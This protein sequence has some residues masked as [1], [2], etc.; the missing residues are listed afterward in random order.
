MHISS[1]LSTPF[2]LPK[3]QK[4][5][6][7]SLLIC[8]LLIP[9][10]GCGKRRPPT[11]PVN[12]NKI[13]QTDFSVFQQGN[14]IGLVIPLKNNTQKYQKA[15][16]YRLAESG[17]AP[18]FLTEEEFASR[19]TLVGSISFSGAKNENEVV[20]FDSISPLNQQRRLRYA[21]RYVNAEG[22]KTQ[23]S[24]F[25]FFEPVSNTAASPVISLPVVSQTSIAF[26]WQPPQTNIDNSSPANVIGYHIYRKSSGNEKPKRI[27]ASLLQSSNFEDSNFKFGEQYEYFVRAVSS[28]SNG[29]HV[30]SLDSNSIKIIPKEVFPPA[31]PE[32]LTVAAAPGNLSVFFAANSETDVIGYNVYRTTNS[33]QPRNQWQKLNDAPISATSYQDTKVESGQRY[34]YYVAAIDSAGNISQPSEMVSEVAP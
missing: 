11:P 20:F 8:L 14:R 29:L 9:G 21:V 7:I 25:I 10:F 3:N 13:N 23:F 12:S 33:E 34:F 5:N 32:G 4:S 28:G 19:S 26:Q 24:N 2:N 15:D 27:N 16:V 18:L 6:L 1:Q 31:A 17:N 22:Q 30:E